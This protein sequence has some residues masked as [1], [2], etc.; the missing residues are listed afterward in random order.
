MANLFS[1][2]VHVISDDTNYKTTINAGKHSIVSDEPSDLGGGD[3]GLMPTQLLAG[4]LGACTSI[5]LRM[6]AERKQFP[7]ENVEVFVNID[8]ISPE[9]NK[10]V[11]KLKLTGVLTDEQKE[12]LMQVANACPVHKIISGKVQI[13]TSWA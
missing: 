12:R 9:E 1:S 7:L 6:Y 11:R 4:A 3:L 2:D 5:T 10:F 8:K 13:E